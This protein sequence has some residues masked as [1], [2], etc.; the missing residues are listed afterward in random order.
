MLIIHSMLLGPLIFHIRKVSLVA[1]AILHE[2]NTRI[3]FCQISCHGGPPDF[4]LNTFLVVDWLLHGLIRS[5]V[6]MNMASK[7]TEIFSRNRNRLG[8]FLSVLD[9]MFGNINTYQAWM[10]NGLFADNSLTN[11]Q[12]AS[13]RTLNQILDCQANSIIFLYNSALASL[14]LPET[15]KF[16]PSRATSPQHEARGSC[17]LFCAKAPQNYAKNGRRSPEKQRKKNPLKM[18]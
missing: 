6:D 4:L 14:L 7:V 3:S 16:F 11:E 13:K 5:K 12:R 9:T 1:I 18:G 10:K 8:N 2:A 15:M 17:S